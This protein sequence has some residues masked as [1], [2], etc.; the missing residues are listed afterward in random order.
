MCILLVT[1]GYLE[2]PVASIFSS[3]D[4]GCRYLSNTGNSVP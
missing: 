3:E 1:Y 4:K 2:E